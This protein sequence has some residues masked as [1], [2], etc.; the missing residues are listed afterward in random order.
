MSLSLSG[1]ASSDS[2]LMDARAEAPKRE[3]MSLE[4]PPPTRE[5]PAMTVDELAKLKQELIDLRDHQAAA[6]KAR[7]NHGGN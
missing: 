5:K 7:D 3:Y 4:D 1:C 2:L 6:I